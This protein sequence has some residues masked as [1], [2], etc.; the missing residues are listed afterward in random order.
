ML[1]YIFYFV[2]IQAYVMKIALILGLFFT[3]A[4]FFDFVHCGQHL[5]SNLFLRLTNA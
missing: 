4:T 5:A 2:Q 3:Y 1:S